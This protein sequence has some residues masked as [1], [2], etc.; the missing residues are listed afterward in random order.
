MPSRRRFAN[1]LLLPNAYDNVLYLNAHFFCHPN[2]LV[3]FMVS[4]LRTIG[5]LR[6]VTDMSIGKLTGFNSLKAI[7]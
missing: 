5:C 1:Y 6:M 7:I 2:S 3:L 4:A